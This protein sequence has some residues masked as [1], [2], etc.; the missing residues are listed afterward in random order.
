MNYGT[1]I[2]W[3]S[4][5]LCAASSIGYYCAGDVRRALYFFFAGCITVTVI[6]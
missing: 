3:I 4:V 5:G 1:L 2:S 6:K